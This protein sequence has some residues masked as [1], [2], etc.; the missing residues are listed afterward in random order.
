M[1]AQKSTLKYTACW[2][3]TRTL[4]NR[5][6]KGTGIIYSPI[7]RPRNNH[8]L[9]FFFHRLGH[10]TSP[11]Y[12][13]KGELD[14]GKIKNLYGIKHNFGKVIFPPTEFSYTY[15]FLSFP[16]FRWPTSNHPNPICRRGKILSPVCSSNDKFWSSWLIWFGLNT[17]NWQWSHRDYNSRF[18]LKQ[19]DS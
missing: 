9:P 2:T 15:Q 1:H 18:N 4:Q 8:Q 3:F 19:N 16:Q 11:T 10:V 7:T 17:T 5:R 6:R 13:R 12:K 14:M